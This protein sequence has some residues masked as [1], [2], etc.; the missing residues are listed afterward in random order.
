MGWHSVVLP[1]VGLLAAGCAVST[2]ELRDSPRWAKQSGE[3][4]SSAR[5][6]KLWPP[7]WKPPQA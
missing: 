1:L 7:V 5:R 6:M 2:A 4:A 3:A